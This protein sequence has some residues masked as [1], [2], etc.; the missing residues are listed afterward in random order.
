MNTKPATTPTTR[1]LSRDEYLETVRRA[2]YFS[3]PGLRGSTVLYY[4]KG[5]TYRLPL[6]ITADWILS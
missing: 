6:P 4:W 3:N 1:S 5:R 2:L